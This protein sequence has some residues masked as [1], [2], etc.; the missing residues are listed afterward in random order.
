MGKL[1]KNRLSRGLRKFIRKEKARFRSEMQDL[2]EI[3]KRI[4]DLYQTLIRK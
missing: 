3:E 4:K 1:Q 2:G